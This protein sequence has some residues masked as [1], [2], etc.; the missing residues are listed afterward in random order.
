ML[1]SS[2]L[3]RRGRGSVC[4]LCLGR[5]TAIALISFLP[6]GAF[7]HDVAPSASASR[8]PPP[9]N[10]I[11]VTG[12][13]PYTQN[14]I[15]RKV[16]NVTKDLQSGSGSA[17]DVLKNIPSVDVDA[18]GGVTIR[19]D[20]N[21]QILI[22]GKPSTT[23]SARTR[24]DA[25]EQLSASSIDHI[26]VIT[27]PGAQYK[28]EGSGGIINI[29]MKKSH[30][31]GTSANVHASAGT[32]GSF[33]LD[34][35]ATDHTG[36]WTLSGS[37]G[38]RRDVRWRP[39][40]DHRTEADPSG[41]QT[42]VK[43]DGLFSGP[44]VA[45]TFAGTID[46]DATSRDRLSTHGSYTHRTGTPHLDQ[47]NLVQ[48]AAGVPTTEYHRYATGHEDE[49]DSEASA[50]YRHQFAGNDNQFTLDLRRGEL[51]ENEN[52]LFHSFYSIP[53]GLQ[54]IDE[55]FPRA[56]ELQR[57]LTAEYARPLGK[58][59]LLV[60][61]NHEQDDDDYLN[62]GI[63]IDPVTMVTTID[64]SR[65]NRFHY[66]QIVDAGY[67]NYDGSIGTK[68]ALTAGLRLESTSI[69]TEP[70][71]PG[72]SPSLELLQSLSISPLRI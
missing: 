50:S 49:V 24:A 54:E 30:S 7:G 23:M 14:L 21:I 3:L 9:A 16:Y 15:D 58:G 38:L 10:A 62:R 65:T 63:F 18:Q 64:P 22:D 67:L 35:T 37:L 47:V 31:A 41:Q 17:A 32:D 48:D 19:G 40:S 42:I 33:A 60:G 71:R 43:Q 27:T 11:V 66:R 68:L 70:D 69:A 45:R 8:Q 39:F 57:E 13:R 29:V 36:P 61:Y 46:Y 4:T 52:R 2:P 12:T 51:V 55:Q 5:S 20:S 25:L 56:D 1:Y 26:E 34:G 28:A 53:A 44:R 6:S 59:K 72:A